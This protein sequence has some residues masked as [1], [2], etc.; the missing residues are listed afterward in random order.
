MYK[1]FQGCK[2]SASKVSAFGIGALAGAAFVRYADYRVKSSDKVV[3][4][5]V[6]DPYLS[7]HFGFD[8]KIRGN[9]TD[10]SSIRRIRTAILITGGTER[11]RREKGDQLIYDEDTYMYASYEGKDELAI[12]FAFYDE[13]FKDMTFEEAKILAGSES[14]PPSFRKLNRGESIF[15]IIPCDSPSEENKITPRLT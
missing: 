2:V 4:P 6:T 1:L 13:D 15:G 7:E 11:D 10:I 14:L 5:I 9:K 12:V 3:A 8:C